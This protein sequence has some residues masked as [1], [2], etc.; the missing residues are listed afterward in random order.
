MNPCGFDHLFPAWHV[1]RHTQG[2]FLKTLCLMV[3]R[4]LDTF[5][6]LIQVMKPFS[7]FTNLF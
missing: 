5:V 1:K 2:Y 6:F 3:L 7:H 4:F